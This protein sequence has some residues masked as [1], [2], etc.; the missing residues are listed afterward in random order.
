MSSPIQLTE[1][2]KQAYTQLGRLH[3]NP[4]P[5]RSDVQAEV[6]KVLRSR[7]AEANT[8]L[9]AIEARP[10]PIERR[11]EGA[12]LMVWREMAEGSLREWAPAPVQP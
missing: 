1:A 6:V 2:L 11:H 5:P 12:D 9:A 8:M 10:L 4:W 3:Q 7:L